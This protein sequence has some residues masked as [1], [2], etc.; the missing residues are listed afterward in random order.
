MI[1]GNVTLS[2]DAAR[3]ALQNE[4]NALNAREA[5][6]SMSVGAYIAELRTN[7]SGVVTQAIASPSANLE[8]FAT[9]ANIPAWRPDYD[10]GFYLGCR[11]LRRARLVRTHAAPYVWSVE[12][13]VG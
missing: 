9:A 8:G 5:M 1:P 2:Y 4:A 7:G 11:I 13:L 10:Q 6:T 3:Q 12:E